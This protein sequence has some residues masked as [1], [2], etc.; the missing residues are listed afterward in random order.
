MAAAAV[1]TLCALDLLRASEGV[2]ELTP[3]A[4]RFRDPAVVETTALLDLGS[5]DD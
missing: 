4:A 1:E 3:V 2:F 5:D